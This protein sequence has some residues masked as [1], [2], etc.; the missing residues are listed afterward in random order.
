MFLK[1]HD[2]NTIF[3]KLLGISEEVLEQYFQKK[4]EN[5]IGLGAFKT[6]KKLPFS[7]KVSQ[8]L[9]KHISKDTKK[10][11]LDILFSVSFNNLSNQF[12]DHLQT[13]NINTDSL[14][15]NYK[16]LTKNAIIMQM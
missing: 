15:E 12:T 4:Y 6:S 14:V 11:D 1:H 3:W 7:K 16:K 10:L 9:H 8:E 13:Y 2:F 5:S